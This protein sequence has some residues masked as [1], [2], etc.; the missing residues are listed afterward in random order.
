MTVIASA[1]RHARRE[2]QGARTETA[3]GD[4]SDRVE[5]RLREGDA[6]F[7]GG[8]KSPDRALAARGLLYLAQAQERHGHKDAVVTYRRLQKE[9]AAD[10]AVASVARRRIAALAPR[11]AQTGPRQLFEDGLNILDVTA[12]GRL[13]VGYQPTGPTGLG[14]YGRRI[15]G[16]MRPLQTGGDGAGAGVLSA[17][18]RFV[19]YTTGDRQAPT[20]G[21]SILRMTGVEPSATPRT[22]RPPIPGVQVMLP[23]AWSPDN[24]SILATFVRRPNI[25]GPRNQPLVYDLVWITVATGDVRYNQDFRELA[26]PATAEVVTRRGVHCLLHGTST[27]RASR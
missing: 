4:R 9:F 18:G 23:R 27:R 24:K 3:A 13:A 15:T 16:Q 25:D 1:Q 22:I 14:L 10:P 21:Q 5:G 8:A 20:E 17:D 7:G 12:D 2:R 26:A 19:A 11:P 6:A